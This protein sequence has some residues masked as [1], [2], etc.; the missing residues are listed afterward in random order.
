MS[1]ITIKYNAKPIGQL[2]ESGTAKL[3][4]AR[5]KCA[6]NIEVEYVKPKNIS[7]NSDWAQ[8][9]ATMSDYIKNRPGGYLY[10]KISIFYNGTL[11]Q[12][13]YMSSIDNADFTSL[14]TDHPLNVSI[15]DGIK[16]RILIFENRH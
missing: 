2:S 10:D 1:D 15:N 12:V 4:T 6:S 9:D 16:K 13:L 3:L 5:K 11:G 8:N 7:V 14:N